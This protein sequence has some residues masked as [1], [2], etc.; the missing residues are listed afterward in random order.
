MGE[1]AY[2][3]VVGDFVRAVEPHTE[4]D[5]NV[6]VALFLAYGGNVMGRDAFLW[7][8]GQEHTAKLFVNVVGPSSTGRKGSANGPI[9]LFFSQVD[10]EWA[11]NNHSGLSSGEG[12]I[13]VVRDPIF[14]WEKAKG[15]KGEAAYVEV[16][17]GIPDKRALI[18]ESEFFGTLQ[19]IRRAGNTLSPVM[20]DAWDKSDLKSMTKNSPAKATGAHIT[21]IG[22]ITKEEL[23][24]GML[25]GEMDNGFANRFLW[26]C[27][28]R[29]KALPEGGRLHEL[30]NTAHW[31]DLVLRLQK[32]KAFAF[33]A[34]AVHRDDA[35]SDLWG[36][37]ARPDEGK[38]ARLTRERHG[39]F[40]AVT[41]RA[42]PQVLRIGLI[43]ARLDCA[44]EMR[45][46]H[47]LAALEVWYCEDSAKFIFGDAMGDPTADMILNALR[48]ATEG[49][50]RSEVSALFSGNTK[51]SEIERALRVLSG[52]GL[53]RFEKE[54]SGQ[55]RSP[56]RWF[57]V[58]NWEASR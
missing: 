50:T 12:L 45:E 53:A 35:A 23:L 51:A 30:M 58:G 55:G 3:G 11:Q 25:S 43:Y 39:L 26:V 1:A 9:D 8:G 21:I 22:N 33:K 7:V 28:K 48:A 16:D 38:Y 20:R 46:E 18:K 15:G 42:A 6:L 32:A 56:E 52:A 36:R 54:K 40:G 2:Y 47:L 34:G 10:Q 19:V 27:S 41:S 37:D 17:P 31:R 29:S 13:W 5:P 4:A 57:A 24:R 49:L 44:R 14:K